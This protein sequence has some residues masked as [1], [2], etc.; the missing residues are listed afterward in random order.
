MLVETADLLRGASRRA[1]GGAGAD[2]RGT[3]FPKIAG[4]VGGNV[5]CRVGLAGIA[6]MAMARVATTSRQHRRDGHRHH[7]PERLFQN[8]SAVTFHRRF[9][10]PG[11]RSCGCEHVG[12]PCVGLRA[13]A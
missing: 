1:A 2:L 9:L 5:Q 11:I 4:S 3:T 7:E 10:A 8:R 6:V 13:W 12:T